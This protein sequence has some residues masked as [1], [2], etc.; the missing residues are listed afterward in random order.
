MRYGRITLITAMALALI[1]PTALAGDQGKTEAKKDLTTIEGEV[2]K[3]YT[4]S[5]D[6]DEVVMMDIKTEDHPRYTVCIGKKKLDTDKKGPMSLEDGDQVS[7][8]GKR[9]VRGNGEM[10]FIARELRHGEQHWKLEHYKDMH[11]EM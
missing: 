1:V 10:V 11:H 2:Q 7:A 8:T 5:M 9:M 4:R 6:G 3:V